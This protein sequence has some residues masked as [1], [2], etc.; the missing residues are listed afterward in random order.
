MRTMKAAF[1][2]LSL[3]VGLGLG[4]CATHEPASTTTTTTTATG[5]QRTQVTRDLIPAEGQRKIPVTQ[6]Y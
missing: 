5:A 3:L 2:C 1:I 6:G 4:S